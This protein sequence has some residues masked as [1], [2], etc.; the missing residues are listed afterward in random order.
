MGVLAG[1]L[2]LV[3]IG[4]VIHRTWEHARADYR[5]TRDKQEKAR[6]KEIGTSPLPP[7]EKRAMG[8]RHRTGWWTSEISHGFPVIRTGWHTGWLAHR[9]AAERTRMARDSELLEHLKTRA[10]LVA[11][12]AGYRAER[13]RLT[14]LIDEAVAADP[15]GRPTRRGIREKAGAV[16]LQFPDVIHDHGNT[17]ET[18]DMTTTEAP[19]KAGTCAV[20]GHPGTET[21]PLR[22]RHGRMVHGP[23]QAPGETRG[24]EA[25]N[26]TSP[27]PS[28][29]GEQSMS[30][31][32]FRPAVATAKSHAALAEQ[33]AAT[34]RQRLLAIEQ[35]I[36][37]MQGDE[38]DPQS[39]GELMDLRDRYAAAVKIAEE[40]SEGSSSF[41]TS[42]S[43]RHEGLAEAHEN[44][45][46]QAAKRDFYQD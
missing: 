42:L 27:S 29:G 37:S 4:A 13:D 35:Q 18:K 39:L 19:A 43:R 36:D 6:E 32:G 34:F 45:P 24:L 15:P 1:Y 11:G 8:R 14:A 20:C 40:C 22:P 12:A 41:A 21:R 25:V 7:G 23:A 5:A 38:V 2:I 28:P 10:S 44:A 31:V 46:V 16:I 33:D 17:E 3:A 26:G 30:E 9:T